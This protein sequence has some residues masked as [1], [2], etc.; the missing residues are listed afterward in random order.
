MEDRASID[1]ARLMRGTSS[2][3]KRVTCRAMAGAS[4]EGAAS[5]RKKPM[6]AAPD[7]SRAWSDALGAMTTGI[8]SALPRMEG[9]SPVT[10]APALAYASSDAPAAFP[11]PD[12]TTTVM[13]W[14]TSDFRLSGSKATRVSPGAVSLRM[15]KSNLPPQQMK[16]LDAYNGTRCGVP[17]HPQ[18]NY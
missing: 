11:A 18:K 9:R 14:A 10:V 4:A 13:P 16:G 8:T 3:L 17:R 2:M 7:L 6:T 12:S 15:P 5:G 1:W